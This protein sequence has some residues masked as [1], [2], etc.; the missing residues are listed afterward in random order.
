MLNRFY[1]PGWARRQPVLVINQL[2]VSPNLMRGG[3]PH[4]DFSVNG[5]LQPTLTM[6]PGEVQLWRIVNT[7]SRSGAFFTGFANPSDPNAPPDFQWKQIAQDGVQFAGPNYD[8]SENPTF[9][10][11]AGNRVDL[12]VKA[13]ANASSEAQTYALIVQQARS[14]CETL[15]AGTLPPIA[16]V[17]P[18]NP[19]DPE[20]PVPLLFVE[21]STSPAA[22]NLTEFIPT[23]EVEASFPTFLGD[24]SDADVQARKTV[25]FESLPTGGRPAVMH[26]ID[27]HKFDGNIGQVVLLNTVEEWKIENRTVDQSI[28]NGTVTQTDPPGLVDHP[29]HIHINPFQ[30]VELFNP[31]EMLVDEK[32]QPLTDPATDKPATGAD[33]KPLPKYVFTEADFQFPD[34][35][36]LLDAGN[37][38]TWKDCHNV[39]SANGV[40][41]DV[42]P[43]PSGAVTTDANGNEVIVPGFFRMRSRFVD[44]TGQYVIHCHILAHEDRGMM[45][46]VDVVPFT[47][48]YSHK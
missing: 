46:I 16:T 9:L 41:W 3:G 37:S 18:A 7:S 42:F 44:Y 39:V 48:A 15:P 20:P 32:G 1:G 10:M 25:V 2:G 12:L 27:G 35:Q 40:W 11:A 24:I 43:I 14:Y 19:C 38:E 6:Q 30:I 45:T 4:Q 28:A 5:R 17:P 8:A 26:T 22:G 33:G 31:N 36:C 29:F 23:D 13:P 21:V 47:T 34:L